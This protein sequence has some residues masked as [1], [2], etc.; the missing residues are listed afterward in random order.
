LLVGD[1]QDT[2]HKGELSGKN[3]IVKFSRWEMVVEGSS[4]RKAVRFL[5]ARWCLNFFEVTESGISAKGV[6]ETIPPFCN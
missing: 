3:A 5:I 6:G 1:W 2:K 4:Y